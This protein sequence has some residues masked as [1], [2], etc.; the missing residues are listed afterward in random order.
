MIKRIYKNFIDRR[1]EADFR[2]GFYGADFRAFKR[3]GV[4]TVRRQ[5]ESRQ[6]PL[7]QWH[8][9]EV[10]LGDQDAATARRT[11]LA[12]YSGIALGSLSLL[13]AALKL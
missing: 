10:W 3:L 12:I 5:F 6:L 9:A 8:A 2:D 13:I 1:R 11:A 7:H 4:L